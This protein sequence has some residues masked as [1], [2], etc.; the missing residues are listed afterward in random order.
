MKHFASTVYC[1]DTKRFMI[2]QIPALHRANVKFLA[3]TFI[4]AFILLNTAFVFS[5][6]VTF[7]YTGAVQ[8]WT[9]PP[10]V[11]SITVTARGA[12]GGG[13]NGGN[14]ASVTGT[15]AVTPG[16][17]LQIRVGGSGTCPTSGYNGG[18]IGRNANSVTNGSCGGGGATDL[19]IAP[20]ALATRVIVAA[21]G[22][23]MGGG[24][25]DGIGGVGGCANG[26]AGASPFGQGGGG[27]SQFLGGNGGPS[28]AG[29][30]AVG[31]IGSIGQGG[32]GAIDPCYNNSPGGGGG[33][34]LYGGG[35]GGT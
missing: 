27:A 32:N 8:N 6:T 13:A 21:G 3:P 10:C 4:S 15:L 17:I 11:T 5:Q 35:G 28:W 31:Q 16:Q 26:L 34:G 23:G 22:G 29:L 24:T 19:R 7:N 14:G 20:Y 18:G 9:V 12:D 1:Y 30:G 25:T 33:G 2:L